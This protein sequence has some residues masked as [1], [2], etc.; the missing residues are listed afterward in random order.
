MKRKFAIERSLGGS[1]ISRRA[2]VLGMT[3]PAFTAHSRDDLIDNKQNI[4]KSG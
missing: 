4:Q 3:N 1:Y 2:V